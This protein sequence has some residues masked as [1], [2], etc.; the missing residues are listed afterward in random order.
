MIYYTTAQL[1]RASGL[2][3]RSIRHH[4]KQGWLKAVP[5]DEL[6]NAGR[7]IR[8]ARFTQ[9]VARKWL[10]VHKPEGKLPQ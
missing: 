4:V 10:Q 6:P 7:G 3:P 1:S 5:K 2:K 8:G 9:S